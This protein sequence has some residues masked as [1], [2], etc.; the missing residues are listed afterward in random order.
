MHFGSAQPAALPPVP[1]PAKSQTAG[2]TAAT[3][4]LYAA[5]EGGYNSYLRNGGLGVPNVNTSVASL[6]GIAQ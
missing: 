2:A 6:L 1:Q 4:Q 5:N 3:K